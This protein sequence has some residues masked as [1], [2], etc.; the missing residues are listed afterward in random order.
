KQFHTQKLIESEDKYRNLIDLASDVILVY[1]DDRV[2]FLNSRVEQALGYKPEEVVG[3]NM[4]RFVAPEEIDRLRDYYFRRAMGE[5]IPPIYESVFL[6]RNGHRVP[7]S[8][9]VGV[10]LYE[11]R[12]ASLVIARD[13]TQKKKTEEELERYRNHLEDIIKQRTNQLQKEINE[14]KVAEESDRLKTAFLSN[15]SHE[16]RTPMNAIISFSNFLKEPDIPEI[17]RNEYLDYILSSGHSLL[18]LINDIIDIAKIEAK[19]LS[20]QECNTNINAILEE[21]YK[22]FEETRKSLNKYHISLR[23]SIPDREKKIILFT[24]PYRLKQILS[25]LINNA[26]KFTDTG[27]ITFGFKIEDNAIL[28]FVQDTGIGIPED[29]QEFIFK[30]FGKIENLGKNISGTGLGL[31]ISKHLASLL[32]GTLWVESNEGKGSNF[33][34]KLPYSNAQDDVPEQI[35]HHPVNGHYNWRGKR[36]LIAEDEDLNF[37]VLQIALRKTNVDVVRAHNGKEALEIVNTSSEIDLILMDIQMPVMDGYEAM[38]HI[39]K[40]KPQLPIIAQT[41][42]ALLEEQSHCLEMGFSDYISKPIK[43]EELFLKIE[44]QL[45]NPANP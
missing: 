10:I 34:L 7:V 24:D 23:L 27:H 19:Q 37:K 40:V 2:K 20:T 5:E 4:N 22:L 13:I 15:M 11:S 44:M 33:Y 30:R 29:K 25:N 21:L 43:P 31:A 3:K 26:L 16:I 42:F 18:N 39:K 6:H 36:I 45:I 28:F 14:R 8:M 38:L 1:Q 9:S 32:H 17:Q 35:V 41:A 12:P